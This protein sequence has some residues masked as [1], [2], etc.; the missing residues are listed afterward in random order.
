MWGKKLEFATLL[1]WNKLD[2]LFHQK[3]M[4]DQLSQQGFWSAPSRNYLLHPQKNLVEDV[5]QTLP[6]LQGKVHVQGDDMDEIAS[7]LVRRGV[8][9]WIPL[10]D[11]L[12]YRKQRVLNGLFGVEKSGEVG[13]GKPPLRLIMNLVPSNSVIKGF[14]GT[15]KTLPQITSWMSVVTEEGEEVRVWQSDMSNAFYLFQ[16]PDNW[17]PL[18]SFN[19]IRTGRQLGLEQQG[20]FALA[21]AVLPMGWA[22]SVAFMQEAS[23]HILLRGNLSTNSLISRGSFLPPWVSGLVSE[24]HQQGK[25]F[26]HVYLDNFAAGE[27]GAQGPSFETGNELH[28]LAEDAWAEAKVVSSAKKRRVAEAQA[29]ELG[30]DID[31]VEQTIGGSPDRLLRL[32]QGTLFLLSKPHLSKKLTQVIAGRWIH[33][34]QFRRP[35]IFGQNLGVC[36]QEGAL[37]F[38]GLA[39]QKGAFQLFMCGAVFT[40]LP[41]C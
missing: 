10:E 1:V 26:W 14:Q 9:R 15:V 40:H 36:H 35:A 4:G 30:A 31:G 12:V 11:V 5:G 18:L 21:C 19:V 13:M 32:I 25:A 34:F 22:K 28:R 6:K 24:S 41:W 23:E 38:I 17:S 39:I 7:E 2:L 3:N 27:V 33:V 8:C 16:I 20:D 29:Q 37:Q